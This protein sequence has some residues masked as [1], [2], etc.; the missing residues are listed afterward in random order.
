MGEGS[1]DVTFLHTLDN[2][3]LGPA[4]I[5]E[6]SD[7]V[8]LFK[9]HISG[10]FLLTEFLMPPELPRTTSPGHEVIALI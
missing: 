5:Q 9:V 7:H 2:L 3:G 10:I 4:V 8:P 1:L 6:E